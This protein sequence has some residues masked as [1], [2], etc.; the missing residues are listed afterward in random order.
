LAGLNAV[1]PFELP[2]IPEHTTGNGH[3]FYL[4]LE[5]REA[6]D[7]LI[8]YLKAH[9]VMAPFHYV[10]LHS[11]PYGRAHSRSHG[12]MEITDDVAARLVRLPMFYTL[13]QDAGRVIDLTARWL[14]GAA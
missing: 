12:P 11:S 7:A 14:R 3:M 13:G 1:R 6:R 9:E 4:L 8:A 10:P 2:R 5:N